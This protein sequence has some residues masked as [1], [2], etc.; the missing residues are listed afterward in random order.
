MR[1]LV[2]GASSGIGRDMAR[3]LSKLG[4]ELKEKRRAKREQ[5]KNAENNAYGDNEWNWHR[6]SNGGEAVKQSIQVNQ[7]DMIKV[8]IKTSLIEWSRYID[9]SMKITLYRSA[10][11]RRRFFSELFIS[12]YVSLWYIR[13]IIALLDRFLY[14]I[15]KV[16]TDILVT[17]LRL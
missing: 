4:Y 1:A 5:D 8:L 16:R 3:Y 9:A 6:S 11:K 13:Y 12:T 7:S 15:I 17:R 10:R 2:T 14:V